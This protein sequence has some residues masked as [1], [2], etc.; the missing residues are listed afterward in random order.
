MPTK[1]II[2]KPLEWPLTVAWVW[3]LFKRGLLVCR[4]PYWWPCP[5]NTRLST[6]KYFV[7]K[8]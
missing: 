4:P 7:L 2:N 6:V 3:S 5:N 1:D 8:H